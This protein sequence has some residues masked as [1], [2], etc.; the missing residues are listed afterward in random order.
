MVSRQRELQKRNV[1]NGLCMICGKP[2][3]NATVCDYHRQL[4]AAIRQRKRD[5]GKCYKS[6]C[7]RKLFPGSM[8]CAKHREE[9]NAYQREWKQ[10]HAEVRR[11]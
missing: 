7:R 1:A 11:A 2:R 10:A 5:A 4:Q 9:K 8:Y 6:K 3:V